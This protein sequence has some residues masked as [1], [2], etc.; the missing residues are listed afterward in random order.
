MED[1]NMND[2]KLCVDNQREIAYL[3]DLFK[4]EINRLE[5][6]LGER[7]KQVSIALKSIDMASDKSEAEALRARQ[8][9]NEWRSAMVDREKR[10]ATVTSLE[11]LDKE[12]GG[13]REAISEWQGRRVAWIAAAGIIATLLAIGV[14]QILRSGI[15]SADVSHQIQNEAPWNRDKEQIEQRITILEKRHEQV[16]IEISRLQQK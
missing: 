12:L 15:S 6:I 2:H 14:G 10:F 3:R 4:G 11:T 8:A 5:T 7:E 13:V 9:A 1:K 16:R